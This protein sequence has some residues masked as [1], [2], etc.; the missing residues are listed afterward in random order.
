MA[1]G[2]QDPNLAPA[3][4]V[5]KAVGSDCLTYEILRG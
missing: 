2:E 3:T 1:A 4:H 5:M